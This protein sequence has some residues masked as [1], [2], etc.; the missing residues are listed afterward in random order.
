MNIVHQD[1]FS[2]KFTPFFKS[3]KL[4]ICLLLLFSEV[5]MAGQVVNAVA[6]YRIA[7]AAV[8]EF[9]AAMS[10]IC[11]S[12]DDT[13]MQRFIIAFGLSGLF[14]HLLASI[15]DSD[16]NIAPEKEEEIADRGGDH[17]TIGPVSDSKC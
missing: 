17:K 15:S 14:D 5:R 6:G 10:F 1:T 12:A 13:T 3:K 16:E 9:E 8:A 4:I 2:V 11:C 7:F